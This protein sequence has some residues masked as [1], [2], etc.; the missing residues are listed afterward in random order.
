MLKNIKELGFEWDLAFYTAFSKGD[1]QRSALNQD[2][3]QRD[4]NVQTKRGS[5]SSQ[6]LGQLEG[7]RSGMAAGVYQEKYNNVPSYKNKS[8]YKKKSTDARESL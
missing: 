6:N 1:T 5:K 3:F 7:S 4:P 8:S 2:S